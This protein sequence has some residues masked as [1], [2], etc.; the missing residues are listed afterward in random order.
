M[1]DQHP[2][3]ATIIPVICSSDK[4]HLT[5]F[6]GDQHGWPLYLT[7]GIIQNTIHWSPKK[8][9]WILIRL[10]PCPAKGAKTINEAWHSVV[11]PV[12]SPLQNLD[13]TGSGMK[14]HCSDGFQRQCHPLFAALVGD[15][16]Q[17]VVI[18]HVACGSCPMC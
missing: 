10:I 2:A 15:Y 16:P 18:A 5:N 14:W 8:R 11:G 6:P 1:Q 7:I 4:S 12:L 17:Q 9:A 3:R 13:I